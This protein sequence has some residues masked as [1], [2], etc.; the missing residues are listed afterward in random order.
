MIAEHLLHIVD[1][2]RRT[3][4]HKLV[5]LLAVMDGL[6]AEA[7]RR[8]NVPSELRVRAIARPVLRIMWQQV[9]PFVPPG[10]SDAGELRQ[11]RP[12]GRGT[13]RFWE[14]TRRARHLAERRGL[15]D[16]EE[17]S[18]AAPELLHGLE[19]DLVAAAVKNPVPRL[20]RRGGDLVEF[21]YRWPWGE[22]RSPRAVAGEQGWSDGEVR[23]EFVPDA[24]EELLRLAPVLRPVVEERVIS[25]VAIYNNLHTNVEAVRDHL[26][27]AERWRVPAR[28]RERLRELQDNRCLYCDQPLG[29]RG[30][31]VDHFVPWVWRPNNAVE[32]LVLADRSCNISKRDRFASHEHVARW[33]EGVPA[34]TEIGLQLGPEVSGVYAD[35]TRS[36]GIARR[37]YE[38]LDARQRLWAG[39]DRGLQPVE[40]PQLRAIA[41]TLE[42]ATRLAAPISDAD[43]FPTIAA[44][45]TTRWG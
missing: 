38:Q 27:G 21:L 41:E 45:R 40:E 25:D 10:R 20:Q 39:R 11:M 6:E 16:L 13:Y 14:L 9:A 17:L 24:A 19:D 23:L 34:R 44:E 43:T 30:G 4:T 29:A 36:L 31:Q 7:D 32:N 5:L 42:G 15:A 26:F 8:G 22:D 18:E 3:G 2:G 35:A 1:D 12:N 33:V 28:L 37:S